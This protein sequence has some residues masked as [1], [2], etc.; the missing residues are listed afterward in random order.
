MSD[1]SGVFFGIACAA[2]F[3][4]ACFQSQSQISVSGGGIGG[5]GGSNGTQ[6][7]TSGGS[8]GNAAGSAAGGTSGTGGV[9]GSS[10]GGA[11]STGGASSSGG[12]SGGP[13]DA[14]WPPPP[15][16]QICPAGSVTLTGQTYTFG[17]CVPG[18]SGAGEGPVDGVQV[19]TL[20]PWGATTS[21]DGGLFTLCVPNGAPFTLEFLA[22]DAGGESF[23][24]GYLAELTL[25]NDRSSVGNP[26]FL[27]CSE[28]IGV[29][30]LQN[31]QWNFDG[32]SSVLISIVSTSGGGA[33]DSD[34]AGLSGWHVQGLLPD[35]GSPAGGWP[36]GYIGPNGLAGSGTTA[37][38]SDGYAVVYNIDP[39]LESVSLDVG[40]GPPGASCPSSTSAF[41]FDGQVHVHPGGFGLFP[42]IIP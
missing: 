25:T 14:G 5:N 28:L 1:R 20:E 22:Q 11:S 42:Y 8:G 4:A 40:G 29:F 19:L 17:I 2:F 15:G 33:C 24:P 31:P 12:S 26:F 9:S 21:A 39:T 6:R 37:T 23:A 7:R 35:G 32:E 13:S 36:V 38:L 41:G 30:G 16:T 34:D 10:S 3:L 18:G 27:L